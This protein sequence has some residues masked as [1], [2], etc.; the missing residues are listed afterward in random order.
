M[1][2]G[3][4]G[5]GMGGGIGGGGGMGGGGNAGGGMGGGMGGGGG[6]EQ[7]RSTAPGGGGGGTGRACT[8]FNSPRGS[9]FFHPYACELCFIDSY[10]LRPHSHLDA[11]RAIAAI[12]LMRPGPRRATSP[13]SATRLTKQEECV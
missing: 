9:V 12:L 4:M 2:G 11:S 7:R 13:A 6:G 3:G 10:L 8:F 1:G 5:G